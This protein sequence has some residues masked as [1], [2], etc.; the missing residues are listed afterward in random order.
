M[1]T[2]YIASP[3]TLGDVGVNVSRQMEMVD[4]LISKSYC[5]FAPLY[6]HYQHIFKPRP[7]EDW[8]KIDVEM[9]KRCDVVLRLPGESA[10]ADREVSIAKKC[11][12][13]VVYSVKELVQAEIN[14]RM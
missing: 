11:G 8:M 4:I 2:V 13:P 14:I 1:I 5:P 12:I 3:Y 6:S 9:L 10:G 7:Y